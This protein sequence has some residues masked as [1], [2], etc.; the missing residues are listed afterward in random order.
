MATV[1][2]A[3]A[4]V[5][6]PRPRAARLAG[7]EVLRLVAAAGIVWFHAGAPGAVIGYGGLPVFVLLSVAFAAEAAALPPEAVVRA[8][9]RRLL[10]P[11][12]AWSGVYALLRVAEAVAR[13]EPP[14]AWADPWMLLTGPVLP[15]WYLPFA[16]A[17]TTA[18]RVARPRRAPV[19][20]CAAGAGLLVLV[21]VLLPRLA[22]PPPV[23]QWVFVAP[24]VLL[25]L[26]L[27]GVPRGPGARRL[28]AGLVG[29]AVAATA[30]A[31]LLGG[32]RFAL[33][34]LV[35][36]AACAVAWC[37]DLPAAPRLRAV[38]DLAF[39][40]FLVHPLVL[41]VA[42]LSLPPRSVVVAAVTLAASAALAA[43]MRRTLARQ[44]L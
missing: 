32:G 31:A 36:V 35:G 2:A 29:A 3:P 39:G 5:R 11:W 12:L 8:Q 20:W 16:F 38:T 15:L 7:I 44:I 27:A 10:V 43:L 21:A 18:V 14:V 30:A 37:V 1:A 13:G 26:G 22:V 24:S 33:P 6:P 40:L 25:G 4:V 34:Y 19:A 23:P 28:A 42:L 17:V 9:A 41:A